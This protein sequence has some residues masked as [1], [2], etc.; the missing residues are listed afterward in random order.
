MVALN[1]FIDLSLQ[2]NHS[3]AECQHII[4]ENSHVLAL[5]DQAFNEILRGIKQLL[6]HS[7]ANF[8]CLSKVIIVLADGFV[9]GKNQSIIIR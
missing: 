1:P 7:Y 5:V 3:V 6:L 9:G 2:E 8:L 4:E